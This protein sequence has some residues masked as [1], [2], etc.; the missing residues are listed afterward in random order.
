MINEYIDVQGWIIVRN[1]GGNRWTE[2]FDHNPRINGALLEHSCAGSDA[3][4]Q[5]GIV[6]VYRK[7]SVAEQDCEVIN[8]IDRYA[9]YAVCPLVDDFPSINYD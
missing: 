8:K 5:A 1:A 2:E 7:K 9:D 4:N 3:A 6:E